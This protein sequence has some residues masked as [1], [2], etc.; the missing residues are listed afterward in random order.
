MKNNLAVFGVFVALAFM[1]SYV[2]SLIP[3]SVGIPGVKL[4]LA[5]IVIVA[6][7]YL[8]GGRE[9]FF[10][11]VVRIFLSGFLFGNMFAILYSLAG[12]I[13]SL[14][15]MWLMKKSSR[16]SVVGVS[17]AGGVSHNIG[18]M[19]V[20]S[21]L[22]PKAGLLYYFPFLLAAGVATGF[23]VGLVSGEI[24]RRLPVSHTGSKK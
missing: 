20:A 24:I 6:A 7:L 1:I 10:L 8:W 3:F 21:L 11:S 2:E 13:L 18:Q 15:V 17:I 12:S 22:L 23:L 16:F 4:G 19:A 14:A 9:A 5:N